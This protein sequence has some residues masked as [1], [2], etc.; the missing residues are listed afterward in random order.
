MFDCDVVKTSSSI[1]VGF[2]V[3]E[4]VAVNDKISIKMFI[5][6]IKWNSRQ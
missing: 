4:T 1:F 5:T 2:A 6:N 3:S